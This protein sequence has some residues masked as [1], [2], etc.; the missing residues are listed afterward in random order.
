MKEGSEMNANVGYLSNI[1]LM[2]VIFCP[3]LATILYFTYVCFWSERI[4][5]SGMTFTAF[6][7]GAVIRLTTSFLPYCRLVSMVLEQHQQQHHRLM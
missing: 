4:K 2:E 5:S 3:D 1:L 7:I 6:E